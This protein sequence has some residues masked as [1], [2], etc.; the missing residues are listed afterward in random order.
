MEELPL[1]DD[2]V[3][4]VSG[5]IAQYR[6]LFQI[7]G[8]IP[9]VWSALKLIPK[10]IHFFKVKA[11]L[12]PFYSWKEVK[13]AKENFIE[14]SAKIYSDQYD[15][16]TDT[17]TQK[18][19]PFFLNKEFKLNTDD[20]RFYLILA[21][22]GMGKTTFLINLY[23][24]YSNQLLKKP[25]NIDLMS[26]WHPKT[27]D[28]L[29][30]Y[31]ED[32]ARNTF[33]L[34]DSLDEDPKA[35][36][37][38]N[39]R[40]NEI[41]DKVWVFRKVVICCNPQLFQNQE[42]EPSFI[43]IPYAGSSTGY[44][45][46][47]KIHIEP[48]NKS[49]IIQYIKKRFSVFNLGDR[50]RAVDVIKKSPSLM[51]RPLLLSFIDDLLAS[52]KK[53]EYA[54]EVYESLI[55]KWISREANLVS[56]G[57]TRDFFKKELF[58][59][60]KEFAYSV[61]IKYQRTNG[62]FLT[63]AEVMGLI[64]SKLYHI[65]ISIFK[66]KSL[67]HRNETGL[68]RFTHFSI[69][70][71]FLAQVAVD[72]K[73]NL[74]ED[75]LEGFKYA[76]IFYQEL[77]WHREVLPFF[78]KSGGRVYT[79]MNNM[80]VE[81]ADILKNGSLEKVSNLFVIGLNSLSLMLLSPLKNI[82]TLQ[83]IDTPIEHYNGVTSLKRLQTINFE[84]CNI[85]N[86]KPLKFLTELSSLYLKNGVIEEIDDLE[87]L[88]NLQYINLENNKISD[89]GALRNLRKLKRLNLINNNIS[90][91]SPLKSLDKLSFLFVAGNPVSDEQISELKLAIPG[92]DIDAVK[93]DVYI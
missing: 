78:S 90:D 11:D 27:W 85:D 63:E 21:D 41:I 16:S 42:S 72:E 10:A 22:S 50:K 61:F 55:E 64:D 29:I 8:I 68:F 23:L 49:D 76:Q 38:I 32:K 83:A 44:H 79:K 2:L 51:E 31:P 54:Y 92:C 62:F 14:T 89:I 93:V 15:G 4:A 28:R 17:P 77:F 87:G 30:A 65:D 33:L 19:I 24:R 86:V 12:H 45:R 84:N 53:Y 80:E 81:I 88:T 26:L 1:F 57:V 82:L 59:L 25:F 39:T 9:I 6:G 69:F 20:Q 52:K 5:F 43:N 91:L 60:S 48:F 37:D 71:F 34:L 47:Q 70:E 74:T 66:T 58:V 40:L 18:L 7:G 75:K 3:G 35:L 73:Y 56:S 67:I 46:F 13:N 36:N